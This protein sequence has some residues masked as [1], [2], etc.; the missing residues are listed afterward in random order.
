[1]ENLLDSILKD[2]NQAEKE[3]IRKAADFAFSNHEGQTRKSGEPYIL[4]TIETALILSHLKLDAQ[5]IAA[6][7][8]HDVPEDTAA[9]TDDIEA[10]FGPE[11]ALLVNGVTKLTKVRLRGSTEPAYIE[12]LQKM[13]VAAA[14]DVRVMLIKLADRLHNMRTLQSL[15]AD[16][17][18]AI[19]RETLEIYAPLANRLGIGEIKGELEDLAFAYVFPEEYKAFIKKINPAYKE[20]NSYVVRAIKNIQDIVSKHNIKILNIH[21]RAKHLY[22]LYK[23]MKKY[24]YEDPELVNDLMAVRI[25]VPTITDCYTV[26]GLVHENYRP[27]PGKIKDYISVPK[28]NGY[29]SLHTSIFGPE[30][31]VLEVQIRT[32][33]MHDYAE[34]GIAAH[35]MYS[36][37]GKPKAGSVFNTSKK[38]LW[39]KQLSEF[40]KALKVNPREFLRTLKM[41]FFQDR[42]FCFTPQGDVIELPV[43]A[44]PIDFAFE[45]HSDLGFRCQGARVN[46]KMVRISEKLENGDVVEVILN[47]NPVRVPR[48]WLL[49]VKTTKAREHVRRALRQ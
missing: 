6:G 27:L 33:E 13:F 39:I 19:A 48:D 4:H 41:D 10:E 16:K 1:M 2:Y 32:Q 44:T 46:G 31:K 12:N 8:L 3:L 28:P 22:S 40:Q 35:W 24:G 18:L 34:H 7:I 26:M 23:K 49:V 25:I 17:Q 21:G 42:I 11:I 47:K 38:L 15:A 20:R 36:E 43:G 45:V 14:A 29:Q 5:T 30:G 9:T 37:S